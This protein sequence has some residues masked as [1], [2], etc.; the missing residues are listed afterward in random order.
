[1]AVEHRPL[2]DAQLRG[3]LRL[4]TLIALRW[5]AVAGQTTALLIVHY[6]LGFPLPLG[7]CLTVIAASAWLNIFSALRFRTQH[8]LSEREALIYLAYDVVQL[9]FLLMLTGGVANPFTLL[10]LAPVTISASVLTLRAT[11]ALASLALACITLLAFVHWPLPWR[12]GEAFEL[13]GVYVVGIW[14]S[15]ILGV[16]F[17]GA[18]AWRIAAERGRMSEALAATQ[19]ILA[20]EQRLTALGGLA[21]SAAHELGTP[22]ATI[23]LVAKE[24]KGEVEPDSLLAEDADLLVAQAQRCRE[25][26]GRLSNRGE[27]GD[28][29]HARM[30]LQSLL[31]EAASPLDDGPIPIAI[32][33]TPA[34]DQ[35]GP[36]PIVRRQPEILYGLRNFIENAVDFAASQVVIEARWTAGS[37]TVAISD[38]GPG[39]A[40]DVIPRL[41]E[42][43]VTTRPAPRS[44]RPFDEARD[45]HEG[46]GLGFFIAKTLLEHS[47]G[48]LQVTNLPVADGTLEPSA[49][50]RSAGARVAVTWPR[51]AI[52]LKEPLLDESRQE[53]SVAL[54]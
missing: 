22:L 24:M 18:Y 2:D 38:D 45:S 26:L 47:G 31:E 41:G 1:M 3:H 17:T 9:T 27:E 7:W 32:R 14:S 35:A 52:E 19:L 54:N 49:D 51:R 40:P 43:Y 46:M 25:I 21:A 37:V 30:S 5:L 28:P 36:P 42:P 44:P 15:L 20:R 6:G 23:Q 4:R 13:P 12:A 29:L 39:F 34:D 16:G 11:L 10:F 33:L 50:G 48:A 8:V 53:E